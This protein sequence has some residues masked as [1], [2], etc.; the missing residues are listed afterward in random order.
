MV[1]LSANIDDRSL[2]LT[3]VLFLSVVV[4]TLFT[5]LLTAPQRDEISEFY[6]GNRTMSPLRNGL[7]MCGDYLS[8]ATLLG[9]TGLVALTGYDGLMYLGGT[10]VAWMMVMLLIAE[11]LHRTGKFT[12]GDTVALRLPRQQRAVRVALAVCILAI[13]TLYLVAQLVGSVT[14]L[15]QFTGEPSATTRTL[16][17]VVIGTFVILYASL[18]GMPG[19]TVIQIIKAVMLVAGVLFTAGWVLHHYDWNPNALLNAAANHSGNGLQFLEPG[20]RYGGSTTNKLDFFSLE[21]AI[22]LGLAALPHVLMR[23][24]APRE[25]SVLRSSV[26]WAV[27]LVGAVCFAAGIVGLGAT[28]VVGQDTIESTDHSGNAAILLLAQELG[29]SVLTALLTCLAYVTLLAVAVGL[30]L[31][32]ASSLAHDLYAEVIRKGRASQTEELTVARLSGVVIGVLGMLLALVAWGANTATLAFLAF[33]IAASAILPTI[34]YTLFWRRFTAQG[35]LLS[36]YGGLICSVVLVVFSPVVSSTPASIYPEAD[37][38]W[39]PLQN[40][41]IVSIPAG[42]LLGWLGTVLNSRQENAVQESATYAEFEERML[43]GA[44][45]E[46]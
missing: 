46:E 17:V 32:A 45:T 16:C 40:P 23:L 8:A 33:A 2:Q 22:V 24:L 6:L 3:F 31:A 21:L 35:A 10:T 11:P 14:L 7:A 36:L 4:I 13:T 28:A 27:G 43:V 12:L 15:T 38:A 37:F 19:A 20:L 34:V 44:A 25:G 29:G 26:L 39:F 9:S 41:G 1:T 30:T 18:G 5:A 42:F